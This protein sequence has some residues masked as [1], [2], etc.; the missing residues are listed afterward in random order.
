MC[1]HIIFNSQKFGEKQNNKIQ[2]KLL[3]Y[4]LSYFNTLIPKAIHQ[5][6]PNMTIII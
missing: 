5:K 2:K 1:I 4:M 3:V 6:S